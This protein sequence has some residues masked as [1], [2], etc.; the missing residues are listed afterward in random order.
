MQ[1][2]NLVKRLR[3]AA[4]ATGAIRLSLA[5]IKFCTDIGGSSPSAALYLYY[6][7]RSYFAPLTNRPVRSAYGGGAGYRPRVQSAYSIHA[8]SAVVRR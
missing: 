1:E 5:F 7:C 8:S 3:Y 4:A 6:R 2:L